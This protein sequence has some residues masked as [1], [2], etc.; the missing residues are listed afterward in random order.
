MSENVKKA[1]EDAR[2]ELVT[3][4]NLTV[5]DNIESGETWVVD[6]TP[7]VQLIDG[8][9]SAMHISANI[10]GCQKTENNIVE[11]RTNM[12]ER[13]LSHPRIKTIDEAITQCQKIET[14]AFGDEESNNSK[15]WRL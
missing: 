2:H 3:L 13:L 7:I 10:G 8:A 12:I 9:L 4:H 6:T 14:F 5:T 11:W 1:L 15:D